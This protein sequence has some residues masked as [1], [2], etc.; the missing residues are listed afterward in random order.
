[1]GRR[2]NLQICL[3]GHLR[4][5]LTV[6]LLS[7]RSKL[8]V[9]TDVNLFHIQ[10]CLRGHPS[11]RELRSINLNLNYLVYI[12]IFNEKLNKISYGIN[13]EYGKL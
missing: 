2:N 7:K 3:K 4:I 9:G 13:C 11:Y 6:Q 8:L 10:N 5:I 12:I 1:M